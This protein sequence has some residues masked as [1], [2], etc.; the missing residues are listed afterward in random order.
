[1]TEATQRARRRLGALAVLALAGTLLQVTASPA[2]ALPPTPSVT[3]DGPITFE[4]QTSIAVHWTPALPPGHNAQIT[5]SD[6]DPNTLSFVVSSNDPNGRSVDMTNLA[7]GT[8][9]ATIRF[10]GDDGT[11]DPGVGTTT[12]DTTPGA[13][14]VH[15]PDPID[16]TNEH[17]VTV[18]GTG[19]PGGAAEISFT[20]SK[21]TYLQLGDYLDGNGAYEGTA[22]IAHMA[23]GPITVR[24]WITRQDWVDGPWIDGPGTSVVVQKTT[25]PPKPANPLQPT[26]DL[27]NSTLAQ[28]LCTVNGLLGKPC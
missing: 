4:N 9:T 26:L 19:G 5:M 25:D 27:V 2:S 15:A 16:A 13:P 6:N 22:D 28:L 20:D 12:K 1:M 23:K 17:A 3:I 21:G 18:T 14:T 11:S 24:V 8:V 10:V 7:N